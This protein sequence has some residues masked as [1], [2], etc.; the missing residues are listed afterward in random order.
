MGRPANKPR[1]KEVE[2]KNIDFV[3]PETGE[4]EAFGHTYSTPDTR[5][6]DALRYMGQ[7][8]SADDGIKWLAEY[9]MKDNYSKEEIELVKRADA[10]CFS[11]AT[12]TQAKLI[13]NGCSLTI[14]SIIRLENKISEGLKKCK[15]SNTAIEVESGPKR[16]SVQDYIA[17]QARIFSG[18]IALEVDKFLQKKN[19]DFSPYNYLMTK[20][21]SAQAAGYVKKY[22][23]TQY[24][25]AFGAAMGDEELRGGY[26]YLSDDELFKYSSFLKKILEDCDRWASNKKAA[27]K[28]RAKKVRSVSAQLSKLKY[29]KEFPELKIVSINPEQMLGASSV[30]LYNT[31]D[32]KLCVYTAR[33]HEGL[34]IK[35]TTLQDFDEKLSIQKKIRKPELIVNRVLSG[36]KV[37]LKHLMEEVK[38]K[39]QSATGRINGF[40]IILKAIK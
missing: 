19:T 30:W 23:N 11:M 10:I 32:R 20:E 1:E 6:S 28:P 5:Y 36:G 16:P 40:T 14:D 7:H 27:R 39:E 13:L 38:A 17:D 21:V 22:Y 3:T 12:C 34:S 26:S 8:Y 2:P 9:M 35:G 4:Y 24:A 33:T 25:E 29:Q 37:V 15:P 31:K 18:D